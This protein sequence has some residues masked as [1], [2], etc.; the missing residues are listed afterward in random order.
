MIRIITKTTVLVFIILLLNLTIKA[1]YYI[2][3]SVTGFNSDLVA[4]GTNTVLL[5]TSNGFDIDNLTG[6]DFYQQGY[7]GGLYGLPANGILNSISNPGIACIPLNLH[8]S[9]GKIK[10]EIAIA[11][12]KKLY[13]KRESIKE[14][15][16]KKQTQRELI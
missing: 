11:K 1:Q 7:S 2:P 6:S 12:G 10:V 15:D 5:S 8:L 3:I 9:N 13:D 14:K 4:N 16:I